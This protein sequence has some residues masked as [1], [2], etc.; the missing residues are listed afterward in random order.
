MRPFVAEMVLVHRSFA[1]VSLRWEVMPDVPKYVK[2]ALT[3]LEQILANGLTNSC[4]F[5][6]REDGYIKVLVEM[7]DMTVCVI[8][9]R[10]RASGS[11]DC[12]TGCV[13]VCVCF[14]SLF[15]RRRCV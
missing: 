11:D 14:G 10:V 15:T 4:K 8:I 13:C 7:E 1:H 2:T 5:C 9:S 3:G 12:F 6:Q